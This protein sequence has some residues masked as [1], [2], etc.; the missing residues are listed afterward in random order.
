M[1]E[2]CRQGRGGFAEV[3]PQFLCAKMAEIIPEEVEWMRQIHLFSHLPEEAVSSYLAQMEKLSY[4]EGETVVDYQKSAP[5]LY[6]VRSGAVRL[7]ILKGERFSPFGLLYAGDYFCLG[8]IFEGESTPIYRGVALSDVDLYFWPL[9]HLVEALAEDERIHTFLALVLSS[10]RK[11]ARRKPKWLSSNEMI[12]LFGGRSK[13]AFLQS[14]LS[15][16]AIGAFLAGVSIGVAL[17]IASNGA[18]LYVLPLLF[19]LVLWTG[20]MVWYW[21]DWVNDYYIVTNK[22]VVWLE[23]VLLLY[24]SRTEAPLRSVIAV[25]VNSDF[26]GRQLGYATLSIRTYGA[27]VKFDRIAHLQEVHDI[28]EDLWERR[29]QVALRESQES[30]RQRI[31]Q[32]LGIPPRNIDQDG[33]TG[34]EA[35][36]GPDLPTAAPSTKVVTK[37]KVLW[38]LERIFKQRLVLEDGTIMYRKHPIRLVRRSLKGMPILA[39]LA[40]LLYLGHHF[41]FSSNPLFWAV[42]LLA[43]LVWLGFEIYQIMDWDNDK[44]LITSTHVVDI[45]RKPFGD[46][47]RQESPIENVEN[48]TYERPSFL[49]MLLNYGD[50]RIQVGVTTM[51]FESV[52]R[53]D[54]VQQEI[55][56]RLDRRLLK[57]R[58]EEVARE[59]DHILDMLKYYHEVV[60]E[61]RDLGEEPPFTGD[62]RGQG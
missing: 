33:L 13:M 22:R 21:I 32:R 45:Y 16:F 31:R 9:V 34:S 46:E 24:E 59:R 47:E 7:S 12:Y 53:P 1:I 35:R 15:Y 28:V 30:I 56:E 44:Y 29:K 5:G 8:E 20:G 26:M 60:S 57:K 23:K 19:L 41:H 62:L 42:V 10:R 38:M 25:S 52:G 14:H 17:F 58:E 11:A 61:E 2:I 18:L 55:Y 4:R 50:V 48:I 3:T 37:S 6:I 51:V 39:G 40:V 36:Q 27:T 54:R 49:A 43:F